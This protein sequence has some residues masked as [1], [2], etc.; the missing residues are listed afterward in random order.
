MVP[1]DKLKDLEGNRVLTLKNPLTAY[2]N[3]K[4]SRMRSAGN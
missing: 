3:K 2:L 4:R 1:A